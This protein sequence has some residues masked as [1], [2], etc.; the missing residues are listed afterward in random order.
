MREGCEVKKDKKFYIV[1]SR[2]EDGFWTMFKRAAVNPEHGDG[3]DTHAEAVAE[4]NRGVYPAWYRFRIVEV[5][6]P[7]SET[8]TETVVRM[9]TVWR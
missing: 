3:F 1:F 5:M 7:V 4:L 2:K 6:T 8:V 9:K